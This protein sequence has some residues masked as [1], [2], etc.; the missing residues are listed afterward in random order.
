MNNIQ[1][2]GTIALSI[3]M[4]SGV[5]GMTIAILWEPKTEPGKA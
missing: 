1:L 5:I 2:Y 4:L 3:I